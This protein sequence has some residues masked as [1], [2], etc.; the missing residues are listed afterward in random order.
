LSFT[1]TRQGAAAKQVADNKTTKYQALSTLATVFADFGD[2]RRKK[3]SRQI[4]PETIV[5][6]IGGYS[7]QCGQGFKN[8]KTYGT[9]S[10]RSPLSQ[11]THGVSKP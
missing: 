1:T 11:Q 10:F 5:A 7:R 2:S 6:E 8:L 3:D 9:S 4:R